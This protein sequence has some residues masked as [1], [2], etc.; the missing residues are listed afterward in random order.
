M[1]PLP[2]TL[3]TTYHWSNKDEIKKYKLYWSGSDTEDLFNKNIS[4]IKKYKGDFRDWTYLSNEITYCYNNKG[5]RCDFDITENFDFSEYTV[6]LGCSHVEGIGT[7]NRCTIPEL[8]SKK[9]NEKVI[10]LGCGGAS[11]EVIYHNLCW[12]LA[13][14]PKPKKIILIWSYPSRSSMVFPV[15]S[16]ADND[17]CRV[18]LFHV[19]TSYHEAVAKIPQIKSYY[20]P[21]YFTD[22]NI[23]QS[24]LYF[25]LIKELSK[26]TKIYDFNIFSGR[27]VFED[28][29]GFSKEIISRFE[30]DFVFWENT[31][32]YILNTLRNTDNFGKTISLLYGRDL[33]MNYNQSPSA[34]ASTFA[35]IHG[36]YGIAVNKKIVDYIIDNSS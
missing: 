8:Y 34:I 30:N 2:I 29:P 18:S 3:N 5:F 36:H 22:H 16:I 11:N 21:P 13:Q 27:E 6:F 32:S 28:T 23:I 9:T 35:H 24:C 20:K 12:L 10:N 14:S 19:P 17:K 7:E 1:I 33:V 25:E 26:T 15:D 4:Y 31:Q